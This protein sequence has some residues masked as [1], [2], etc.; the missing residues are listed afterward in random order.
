MIFHPKREECPLAIKRNNHLFYQSISFF[1]NTFVLINFVLF[2]RD[3]LHIAFNKN[4]AR[5]L[6]NTNNFMCYAILVFSMTFWKISLSDLSEIFRDLYIE[7]KSIGFQKHS[8]LFF[9]PKGTARICR[10]PP[11]NNVTSFIV[12]MFCMFHTFSTHFLTFCN[13]SLVI[14]R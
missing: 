7:M 14:C 13:T 6:I 10:P 11:I 2:I 3:F 9:C 5:A 8:F 12:Y 4:F 1:A